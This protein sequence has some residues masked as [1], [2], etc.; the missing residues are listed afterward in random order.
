MS[1]AATL[2][3]I[4][5]T[6]PSLPGHFPG[7]PVV[8]GAVILSEVAA[9]GRDHLGAVRVTGFAAVKFLSPL[10]PEQ[11]AE[12]RFTDKGPGLSAFDVVAN[13][14]RIASGTLRYERA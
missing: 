13:D 7:N 1:H 14:Q 10:R 2:L 4:P 5:A 6:H 11:V 12:I 9:A 8:P 3:K